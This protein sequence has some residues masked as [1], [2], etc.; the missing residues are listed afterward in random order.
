MQMSAV[1][2]KCKSDLVVRFAALPDDPDPGQHAVPVLGLQQ[3]LAEVLCSKSQGV[4]SLGLTVGN[5]DKT[6]TDTDRRMVFLARL[7]P[8]GM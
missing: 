5:V 6:A 8:C 4:L 2:S 7:R 3:V 1:L